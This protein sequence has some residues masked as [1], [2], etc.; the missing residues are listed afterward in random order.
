MFGGKVHPSL[1][2]RV[3]K[4]DPD[5]THRVIELRM[6]IA[7]CHGRNLGQVCESQ[8]PYHK[9]QENCAAGRH[10]LGTFDYHMVKS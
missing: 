5:L 3:I 9:S 1:E 10:P 6:G 2:L 4:H 8:L 7:I